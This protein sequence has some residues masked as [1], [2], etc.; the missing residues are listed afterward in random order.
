VRGQWS[1]VL[2]S[3]RRADQRTKPSRPTTRKS[4]MNILHSLT[5]LSSPQLT[6]SSTRTVQSTSSSYDR[7]TSIKIKSIFLCNQNIIRVVEKAQRR[8]QKNEKRKAS[9]RVK[10]Y[11]CLQQVL[12]TSCGARNNGKIDL[13]DG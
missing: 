13:D 5:R 12:L 8:H 2:S 10:A 3:T 7:N 1:M 6:P 4:G 11:L 9:I